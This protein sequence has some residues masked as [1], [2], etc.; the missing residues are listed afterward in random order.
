LDGYPPL[1]EDRQERAKLLLNN[2][3]EYIRRMGSFEIQKLVK[4]LHATMGLTPDDVK[5]V[6]E[7]YYARWRE[8]RRK[9]VAEEFGSEVDSVGGAGCV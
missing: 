5:E 1:P 3:T 2:S 9:V 8:Q 7:E 6:E 4:A